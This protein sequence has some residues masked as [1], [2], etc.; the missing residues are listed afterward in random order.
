[1]A[2]AVADQV[3]EYWSVPE[4]APNVGHTVLAA[5]TLYQNSLVMYV[6]GKMRPYIAATAGSTMGGWSRNSY[7]APSGADLVLSNDAPAV[8]RRECAQCVGLAG[9]LPTDALIGKPVAFADSSGTVKATV[10]TNDL[11]GTLRAIKDGFFWVEN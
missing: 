9:D 3:R 7:T 2:Q 5:Q 4:R 8:L 10:V 6:A 11:T 1:M